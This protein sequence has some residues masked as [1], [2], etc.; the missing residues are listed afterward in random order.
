MYFSIIV[1]CWSFVS[2]FFAF[3]RPRPRFFYRLGSMP[4]KKKAAEKGEVGLEEDLEVFSVSSPASTASTRSSSSCGSLTSDQLQQ[5]LEHTQKAML[6]ASHKSM[7][8]LLA[9]LA[10]ATS[11]AADG[12]RVVPVKVPKWTDEE[13]PSEYFSKLEKALSHNRVDR[14]SWGQ[15]LPVYLSGRA[16]AALA[17]VD[18]AAADDYDQVKATQLESL[19]DTPASA[20]RKWWT[21]SRQPG[22]E[23]GSFYLRVRSTGT[24]RLSGLSSKEEILERMVLSRYLSL[25][26]PET[27]NFVI[28]RQPN[29]GLEAARITQELEETRAFSRSRSHWKKGPPH[30]RRE[31][32]SGSSY[33]GC[34]YSSNSDESVGAPSNFDAEGAVGSGSDPQNGFVSGRGPSS[35]GSSIVASGSMGTT[36]AGNRVSNRKQVT[37]HGCGELGHIR[38]DCP[39]KIRRIVVKDAKKDAVPKF[40]VDG[41]LDGVAVKGL[42]L[43]TGSS[44]TLVRSDFVPKAAYTGDIAILDSWRGGQPSRHKVARIVIQIGSIKRRTDVVVVD[45]LDSPAQLGTNIGAALLSESLGILLEAAKEEP[46]ICEDTVVTMQEEE[47]DMERVDDVENTLVSTQCVDDPLPLSEIFDFS[48]SL[49]QAD[50]VPMLVEES[51]LSELFDFSDDLFEADPAEVV[52]LGKIEKDGDVVSLP[53]K[54]SV[55]PDIEYQSLVLT[56][57]V[58]RSKHF[59]AKTTSGSTPGCVTLNCELLF[60]FFGVLLSALFWLTFYMTI[61]KFLFQPDGGGDGLCSVLRTLGVYL[62]VAVYFCRSLPGTGIGGEYPYERKRLNSFSPHPVFRQQWGGAGFFYSLLFT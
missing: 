21:L 26:P 43:D 31:S 29:T 30:G 13:V 33:N 4:P 50:P 53:K 42:N 5:I 19:G 20:D 14:S 54:D 51:S 46:S 48:D 56:D 9:G 40:L 35:S 3:I 34:G 49:F 45:T 62:P 11:V 58:Q 27:Y 7:T 36:P 37:C 24:R 39:N 15:V 32:G 44:R 6:E 52:V 38:P 61:F 55:V 57:C 25:L 28:A 16:Q 12:P 41:F 2:D 10:P 59:D 18:P 1:F 47:F 23:A 22:E 60:L 8:A 17:Q